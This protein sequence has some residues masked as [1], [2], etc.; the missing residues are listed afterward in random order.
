M[1]KKGSLSLT[2][3]L[4]AFYLFL[5]A[6]YALAEEQLVLWVHPYLPAT[7]IIKKFSPLADYLSTNTCLSIQ[8]KVSKTYKSHI[9]NVG[10]GRTDLAYLGPASYVKLAH[11]YGKQTLLACLKVNGNP[12]FHGMIVVREN[13]RITTL[14]DLADKKFA[15]SDPNSTM[16][17]LVP[18]YMLFEKGVPIEALKEYNFLGSH[19]DVALAVI[20]GYYD[21]GSV[22]EG[23]YYKYK[24][25]GLKMLAQSPPISEHLF[26]VNKNIPARIV[27]NV[28]QLLIN[29]KDKKIL[30]SIKPTVTGF[31][32]VQDADYSALH[33]ILAQFN[34]LTLE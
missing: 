6:D 11:I 19:N 16:G 4:L 18:R 31:A 28:R 9:K 25:R 22:K 33:S 34:K 8:I 14:E 12:Y 32:E 2:H 3:L 30:A 27:Y 29:L 7:E 15:F 24:N 17:Y 21:A 26:V 1:K 20:G 5:I 13:S 23:V 10:E